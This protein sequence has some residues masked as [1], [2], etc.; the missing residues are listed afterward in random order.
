M[1]GG[2][3]GMSPFSLGHSLPSDR[4]ACPFVWDANWGKSACPHL[5]EVFHAGCKIVAGSCPCRYHPQSDASFMLPC[6]VMDRHGHGD[7]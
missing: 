4:G 1:K 3:H 2:M 7:G 6:I 5:Q